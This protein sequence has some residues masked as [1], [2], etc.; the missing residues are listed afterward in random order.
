MNESRCFKNAALKEVLE[1]INAV[2]IGTAFLEDKEGKLVGIFTDGD[3]R[4]LL[5]NGR[6]LQGN[7]KDS[8]F[9]DF[10]YAHEGDNVK[11]LLSKTNEKVRLIP[12]CEY[13]Y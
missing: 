13:P 2:P 8:D 3:F 6:E 4:R 1:A 10:V 12:I 5:L 7:L 11:D 9:G